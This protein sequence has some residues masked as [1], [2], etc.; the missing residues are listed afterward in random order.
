VVVDEQP[1]SVAR[2]FEELVPPPELF[3]GGEKWRFAE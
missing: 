3:S 2:N 1:K